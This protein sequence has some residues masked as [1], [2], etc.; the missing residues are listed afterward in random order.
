MIHLLFKQNVVL[1]F[2]DNVLSTST[3]NFLKKIMEQVD[4]YKY[5]Q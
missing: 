5:N 1:T 2:N 4:N 3:E